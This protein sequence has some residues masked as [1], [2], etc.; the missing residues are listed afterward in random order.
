MFGNHVLET[1]YLLLPGRSEQRRSPYA[2]S[3]R[4]CV[5]WEEEEEKT[6]V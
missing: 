6:C 1:G 3:D 5:N 4:C 2:K